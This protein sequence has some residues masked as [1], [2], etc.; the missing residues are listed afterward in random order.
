MIPDIIMIPDVRS[1]IKFFKIPE[2]SSGIIS[3]KWRCAGYYVAIPFLAIW[4][5]WL[6][7]VQNSQLM[8]S[9]NQLYIYN[10]VPITV[11]NSDEVH[12]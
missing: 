1:H 11:Q 7:T 4:V 2:V 9:V 10:T 6:I 8:C 3:S 12:K 5:V